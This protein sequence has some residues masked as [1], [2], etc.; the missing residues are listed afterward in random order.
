MIKNFQFDNNEYTPNLVR[1]SAVISDDNDLQQISF[2]EV[3]VDNE[4]DKVILQDEIFS[5]LPAKLPGSLRIIDEDTILLITLV[6]LI[7]SPKRD[8]SLILVLL[9]LLMNN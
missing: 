9:L 3:D 7:Q 8:I 1:E 2:N 4:E 6:I 5:V